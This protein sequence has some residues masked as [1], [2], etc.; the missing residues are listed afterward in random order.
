MLALAEHLGQLRPP[1]LKN[2]LFVA[3]A[4]HHAEEFSPGSK[5]VIARYPEIMAKVGLVLNSEHPA[6]L[7][8][9]A[10][11]NVS[12]MRGGVNDGRHFSNT[13]SPKFVSVG[14]PN[15]R[16]LT[17]FTTALERYGVTLETQPWT[18]SAG[19]A[20]PFK[21]AGHHVAQ[22]IDVNWWYHSTMDTPDTVSEVG[23]E[24]AAR[25][26]ADFLQEVDSITVQELRASVP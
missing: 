11:V 19:A 20:L 8:S 26:F 13:E 7:L 18:S 21:A 5:D 22:I 17:V 14:P 6:P 10:W 15:G 3:T 24:R 23:L 4:S 25:A 9:Q 16:L 2:Y 1:P 12:R